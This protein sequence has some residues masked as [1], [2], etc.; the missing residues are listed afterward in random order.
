MGG[1]LGRSV[2]HEERV[3]IARV[4]IRRHGREEGTRRLAHGVSVNCEAMGVPERFDE[5]LTV[6]W[7][8]RIADALDAGDGEDF[9]GFLS[10]HPELLRGDPLGL[11]EWLEREP[12][13]SSLL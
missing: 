3:R 11:P 2:S 5:D 12:S 7:T 4:L 10:L 8:A 9:D 6:R 13:N 1:P